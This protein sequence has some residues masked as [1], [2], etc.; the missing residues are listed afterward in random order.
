MAI[1]NLKSEKRL[2]SVDTGSENANTYMEGDVVY[3]AVLD[4]IKKSNGTNWVDVGI[5]PVIKYALTASGTDHYIW[6]GPGFSS[7]NDPVV[8][9]VRG[10]KYQFENKIGSHPFRVSAT[11]G[12]AAYT[13]GIT[14]NDVS[15]GILEWEVMQDAPSEMF[16][17]STSDS[18]MK[19]VFKILDASGTAATNL[20]VAN[21]SATTLR[22]TSSTGTDADLPIAD[23]SNAGLMNKAMFDK[24]AGVEALAEVNLTAV[25]TRTLVGTGNAG[26][27]PTVG[28]AG[29]FLK[30]DGSFGLPSYTTNTDTTYTVG[31]GGLSEIS[32]TTADNT[33]LDGIAAGAEV[34]VQSDWNSVSGDSQI[35]NKPNIPGTP[36]FAT[37]SIVGAANTAVHTELNGGNGGTLMVSDS[38]QNAAGSVETDGFMVNIASMTATGTKARYEIMS[39]LAGKGFRFK[40]DTTAIDSFADQGTIAAGTADANGLS[41]SDSQKLI[42]LYTGAA[43]KYMVQSI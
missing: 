29:H 41:V 25:E 35:L 2:K 18:A 16:Y 11:D 8:Y 19:G 14:N 10:G 20:A 26:V 21:Q 27:I 31:D 38:T 6:N 13:D 32:F 36:M 3:S 37:K 30:H 34:N 9:L 15:N 17:N 4:T 33:K 22:V 28:T 12:G 40:A 43:W 24:L 42:I 7:D 39:A 5:V 1:V 23:T